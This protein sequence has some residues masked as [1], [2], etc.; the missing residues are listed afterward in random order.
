MRV[1]RPHRFARWRSAAWSAVV[2]WLFISGLFF[3]W[4]GVANRHVVFLYE[5]LG[6]SPFDALT[7][8][9]YPMSGLV[10]AGAVLLIY[11]AVNGLLG[12]LAA[13]WSM[14]YRPPPWWQVWMLSAAPVGAS[15]LTVTLTLNQP[16]LSLTD[17]FACLLTTL[18]GLA[19]ALM[20]GALA[21]EQ[22]EALGW[23]VLAGLGLMPALLLFRLIEQP[24][25]GLLPYSTAIFIACGGT[26]VG[27]AWLFFIR[28]AR[29]K[30]GGVFTQAGPLFISG[31]S[32]S[33]LVLP[34]GHYLF[35]GPPGYHYLTTASNFFASSWV[36]QL[37]SWGLAA[38][39]AAWVSRGQ[40]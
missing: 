31:L 33:Y 4:Y 7:R 32:L 35:L 13:V 5:H 40:G 11:T 30:H 17:A 12:R 15:V 6:L 8:S 36:I 38:G 3:Y 27:V 14:T 10:A 28:W 16:T 34:L 25:Q 20:P 23:W 26:M 19:L 2:I 24:S 22:P 29:R 18:L 21:A 37:L 9:R 1:S 39:L